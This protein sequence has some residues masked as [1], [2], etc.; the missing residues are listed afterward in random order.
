M[1]LLQ[2]NAAA[3]RDALQTEKRLYPESEV[4][5]DRLLARTGGE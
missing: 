1:Y 4:F 2:G 3:A 5:V